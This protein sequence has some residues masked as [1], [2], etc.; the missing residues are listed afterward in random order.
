VRILLVG[1]GIQPIPPTGYGGVERTISEFSV[2]LRR[3][4]HEVTIINEV[5]R[6]RMRDEYPF[7]RSL[8]VRLRQMEFDVLHASTPVVARA[9]AR[10]HRSFIYTSHS[11]HWFDRKGFTDWWGFY[12]ERRAVRAS[13]G[14]VALTSR[15]AEAMQAT[16][17]TDIRGRL[18]VIP[19]GVDADRFRPDW[20]SRTGK[21]ALGVGAVIRPK[22]WELAAR[23]LASTD[24]EFRLVGP[25]PDPSYAREVRSAGEH[26]HLIGEVDD[27]ALQSEF[28]RADFLIHPSRVEVLP[29]VVLQAF[30]AGLPVVGGEAI[31]PVVDE[32]VTGW[33]ASAG[34]S[35]EALER[36]IRETALRLRND[37]TVR[38][39]VGEA[40][41]KVAQSRF[42]WSA[43]VEAHVQ[44]YRK[45][46]RLGA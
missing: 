46:L 3:A 18:T 35:S 9:L 29:G 42:S 25:T 31:Q 14:T 28:A 16:V 32:G 23:A 7:A 1:T 11:R 15:L 8:E 38:R 30:A 43:I 37:P 33:C 6:G 44:F 19:I 10:H 36:F 26:T 41:R 39:T 40:G 27:D 12:L 34:S 13:A 20:N 22:R 5:R 24:I 2:A 21:V 17:T 45:V 4:G